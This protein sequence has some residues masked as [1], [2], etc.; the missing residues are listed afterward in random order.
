MIFTT[1]CNILATT[2]RTPFNVTIQFML[3]TG[4][5]FA[6]W[7]SIKFKFWQYNFA[8]L[9]HF[10]TIRTV[11]QLYVVLNCCWSQFELPQNLLSPH[12]PTS[13][14]WCW[15]HTWCWCQAWSDCW[16]QAWSSCLCW[17]HTRCGCLCWCHTRCCRDAWSNCWSWCHTWYRYK[18][19]IRL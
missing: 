9:F 3:L 19:H 16:C 14:T 12:H 17:C 11:F 13:N 10:I 7:T 2:T 4:L 6:I 5:Y 1:T 18:C 8:W 15:R